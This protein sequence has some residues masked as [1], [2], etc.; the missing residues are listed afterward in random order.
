MTS[1]MFKLTQP[2]SGC[3]KFR[4]SEFINS[5][6]HIGVRRNTIMLKDIN[7][8]VGCTPVRLV[9]VV[10]L[11]PVSSG[12]YDSPSPTVM[13]ASA[14]QHERASYHSALP[15]SCGPSTTAK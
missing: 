12:P 9:N 1:L 2:L 3:H 11:C 8:F 5:A 10:N 14:S 6:Y 7:L 13:L 4:I 15:S